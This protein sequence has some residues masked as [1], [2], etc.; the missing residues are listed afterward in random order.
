MDG[1]ETQTEK[2]TGHTE[3]NTDGRIEKDLM[4]IEIKDGETGQGD[5]HAWWQWVSTGFEKQK[6]TETMTPVGD[7]RDLR[8]FVDYCQCTRNVITVINREG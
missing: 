8:V 1:L 4:E 3:T 5:K 2:T 6:V 7:A